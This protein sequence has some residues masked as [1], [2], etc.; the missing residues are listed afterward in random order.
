MTFSKFAAIMAGLC[1][2]LMPLRAQTGNW[3]YVE[4]LARGTSISVVE[5]GREGCAL[6]NVTDVQLVCERS[7]GRDR[8]TLIFPRAEVREIRM[9]EPEHNHLI[10]GAV[11]GGVVGALVGFVGGGQASDPEARGYARAFGI[12]VGAVVGGVIGHALHRHGA[13]VY[14]RS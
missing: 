14:R 12:P 3:R 2:L 6:V 10:A 13:V 8:R 11:I 1:S 9:E 7:I 4:Q 5:R